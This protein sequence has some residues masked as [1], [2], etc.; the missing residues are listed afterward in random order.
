MREKI[1][2][3]IAP[4]PSGFLHIGNVFNF[5]LTWLHV[6]SRNGK[7]NLRIDDLDE[8][9]VRVVFIDQIFK[10][11]DWLGLDYDGGPMGTADF[12][13]NH[14]QRYRVEQYGHAIELL[15]QTGETFQCQCSRKEILEAAPLGQYPGTC[16]GNS[17]S[18]D[19]KPVS[20]RIDTTNA[21]NISLEEWL[22]GRKKL[23]LNEHVK[24][25]I[26]RRKDGLPAYQI[27]SLLDDVEM[28]VNYI[29]RGKDLLPSSFAQMYLAQ[30]LDMQPFVNATFHHHDLLKGANKKK[31][32]K[33]SKADPVLEKYSREEIFKHFTEWMG[34]NQQGYS[35]NELLEIYTQS[36]K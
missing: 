34:W 26:I 13:K 23:D 4:T 3:R 21:I 12:L 28:Q 7:L 24:D 8:S 10:V 9:R 11:L 15:Q 25:F 18:L 17:L 6:R 27:A 16:K 5:L 35:L 1:I 14:R 29:V 19:S 30:L 22:E 36:L 32:S 31:L 20:I 33:S 2:S